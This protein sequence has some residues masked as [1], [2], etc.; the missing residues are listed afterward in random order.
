MKVLRLLLC[1]ALVVSLCGCAGEEESSLFGP[2]GIQ[3]IKLTLTGVEV[4]YTK[5]LSYSVRDMESDEE[6][7]EFDYLVPYDGSLGQYRAMIHLGDTQY[8]DEFIKN[9]PPWEV[10]KLINLFSKY[11]F[12][13]IRCAYDAGHGCI[14]YIGSDTPFTVETVERTTLA[15]SHGTITIPLISTK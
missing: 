7:Y 9:T 6:W 3:N 5:T 8:S 15:S 4:S 13:K 1:L 14:I 2:E 11:N 12:L 10:H